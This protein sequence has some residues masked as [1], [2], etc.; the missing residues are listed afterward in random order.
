M[1]YETVL[2]ETR[3]RVGLITLN[4]PKALNALTHEMVVAF[5]ARLKAWSVDPSVKA[6]LGAAEDFFTRYSRCPERVLSI[7][8]AIP[9]NS[10]VCT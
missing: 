9:K 3:G 1:A 7:I 2:V 5:D 6:L 10:F 8:S 4:R